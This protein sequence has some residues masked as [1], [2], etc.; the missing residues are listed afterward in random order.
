MNA[1]THFCAH[2]PCKP[3]Q[4]NYANGCHMLFRHACNAVNCLWW[5]QKMR[6][7]HVHFPPH[8]VVLFIFYSAAVNFLLFLFSSTRCCLSFFFFLPLTFSPFISSQHD[9]QSFLCFIHLSPSV[10]VF[11]SSPLCL[12]TN[13]RQFEAGGLRCTVM[14]TLW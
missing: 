14:L 1:Y 4:W 5:R 10:V 8:S 6:L 9:I 2:R 3:T 7:F 11:C 13:Q 12:D